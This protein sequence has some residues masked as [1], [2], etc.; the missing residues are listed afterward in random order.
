[1]RRNS[2]VSAPA[3]ETTAFTFLLMIDVSSL[4]IGGKPFFLLLSHESNAK[5]INH[6]RYL[7]HK[8]Y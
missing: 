6:I 5:N 1:M 3:G 7:G 2:S 8:F 4:D